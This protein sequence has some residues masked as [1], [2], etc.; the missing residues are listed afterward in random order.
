MNNRLVRSVVSVILVIM[1]CL[2]N[3]VNMGAV[4]KD[5]DI[6]MFIV[7]SNEVLIGNTFSVEVRIENNPGITALQLNV[8]YNK[9]YI[10]L[11]D[12]EH[13]SLFSNVST[14][15]NEYSSPFKISWFSQC[16]QDEHNNGTLVILT[17]SV[18]DKASIGDTQISLSYDVDNVFNSDF[19]NKK[20]DVIDGVISIFEFLPGDVNSDFKINMR[21]IVLLQKW[22]NGFEV[23]IDSNAADIY[24]DRKLN[25]KDVVLLQC[26]LNGDDVVL[27]KPQN[28]DEG[29]IYKTFSYGK[30]ELGKDLICHS[31]VPENYS[32]TI[33]LNFAIH[34]YEDEYNA[35]GQVLV[36]TA[37]TLIEYYKQNPDKLGDSQ[38]IIV[39]CANPDGL[40][41]GYTKD[42]FGR[43]N[44]NGVDLNRDFDANYSPRTN[45]RNYTPYAFS[46]SESRALR[47]LV[48]KYSADV[49]VDFHGWLNYTIGDYEL[50]RVFYEE[51]GLSHNVG[52]TNSN[53]GGYFA[54]WA[55]QQGAL[56][57]LV[58]FTN[59]RSV[60]IDKLISAT[61]RI[62]QNDYDVL[63]KDTT[64]ET[65]DAI[66][67]YPL[68]TGQ[69]TTY[70]FVDKPFS[71][72]SYI[73]GATDK[74]TILDVYDN[75]W[76]RVQYPRYDG[77][78]KI[79]YCYLSD[80]ISPDEMIEKFYSYTVSSNTYVYRRSDMSEQFGT[81]YPTDKITVVAE[82]N[83]MLQI[84]Y[85][86]DAGGY[87]MGWIQNNN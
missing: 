74:T 71:T 23:A 28:P 4:S 68:S 40:Y 76:V 43:C 70:E 54:N 12:V 25:M 81:V 67:C 78:N 79:A 15:S 42:G 34:G 29:D 6:P 2:I 5:N 85:N 72:A 3:V 7:T 9:D 49:V 75:S 14:C 39:P 11:I 48:N 38:L 61:N 18:S 55:H 77:T 45:P 21:D 51:M 27:G 47:D 36:D 60:S 86:L 1:F 69:V 59:S 16:S 26:Y 87:K 63:N 57:L 62:L 46:A 30:S 19:V 10:K 83:N 13:C 20:F 80:F 44:A 50:A 37:Y 52:F 8:D 33:L 22:L 58:E 17:F 31:F 66:E 41:D 35:D 65:Y 24:Y 73:D 56:G 64:F 82:K 84:I 32:E 53:A